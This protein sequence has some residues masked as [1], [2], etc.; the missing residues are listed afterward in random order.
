MAVGRLLIANGKQG[1]IDGAVSVRYGY[2]ARAEVLGTKGR[3][4]DQMDIFMSVYGPVGDDGYPDLLYDKWTGEIN[5]EV[6]EYWREN[7]D[8]RHIIE[9][10]WSTL[11][12]KLVGKIH[13]FAGD[14]DNYYLNNAVY[15][16][17]EFLESTTDPYYDGVVDYGD[18]AYH[19]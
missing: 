5:P 1:I 4:G 16:T 3:S 11:G 12:P 6:A 13:I 19:C 17:E 14:M 10:D 8:L 7:Y 9:R 15:L 2:D 18:R